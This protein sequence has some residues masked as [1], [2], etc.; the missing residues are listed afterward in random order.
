M[1]IKLHSRKQ[2]CPHAWYIKIS[3]SL[4][5]VRK[6]FAA[7]TI[8]V[9]LKALKSSLNVSKVFLNI[10]ETSYNSKATVRPEIEVVAKKI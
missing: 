5:Y 3:A 7:V 6:G 4:V 1:S 10:L 8:H 2:Y 9:L